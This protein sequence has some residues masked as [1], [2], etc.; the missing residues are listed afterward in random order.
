MNKFLYWASIAGM[1]NIPC[2][3]SFS[4]LFT[5]IRNFTELGTN[6]GDFVFNDLYELSQPAADFYFALR[7]TGQV[8]HES[9][10]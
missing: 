5:Q 9:N 2:D 4:D 1:R 10:E 3:L 8:C 7:L 6:T